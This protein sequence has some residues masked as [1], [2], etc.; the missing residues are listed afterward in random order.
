MREKFQ[1]VY[2]CEINVFCRGKCVTWMVR[3]QTC[4]LSKIVLPKGS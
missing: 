2:E 1:T 3:K 4:F